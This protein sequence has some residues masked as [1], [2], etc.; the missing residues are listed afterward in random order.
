MAGVVFFDSLHWTRPWSSFI[1]VLVV[2]YLYLCVNL[3][4]L[5][6]ANL[7]AGSEG[8]EEDTQM[9]AKVKQLVTA[10]GTYATQSAFRY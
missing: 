1:P 3:G 5:V 7:I 4:L 2:V 6:N 8:P 10:D 9:T